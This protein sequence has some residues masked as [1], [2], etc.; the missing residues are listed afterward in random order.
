MS[1][2]QGQGHEAAAQSLLQNLLRRR[3]QLVVGVA[4]AD[5]EPAAMIEPHDDLQASRRDVKLTADDTP[6][7]CHVVLRQLHVSRCTQR[8]QHRF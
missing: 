8:L 5:A 7:R 4:A 2:R 1:G 3:V 6:I